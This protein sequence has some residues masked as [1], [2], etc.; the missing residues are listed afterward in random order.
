L[1]LTVTV[2]FGTDVL[3]IRAKNTVG[4]RERAMAVPSTSIDVGQHIDLQ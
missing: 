4:A 2:F 1:G 3:F